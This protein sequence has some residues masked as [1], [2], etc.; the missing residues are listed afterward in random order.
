MCIAPY[1]QL[2]NMPGFLRSGH[3]LII[4]VLILVMFGWLNGSYYWGHPVWEDRLWVR[5][6]RG[7]GNP[8]R[9]V[10]ELHKREQQGINK[11]GPL[12]GAVNTCGPVKQQ[13]TYSNSRLSSYS[14]NISKLQQQQPATASSISISK[15]LCSKLHQAAAAAAS[16]ISKQLCRKLQQA[17]AL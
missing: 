5:E 8:D 12:V 4:T 17:P 6:Y 16:S 14:H 15:Q 3:I 9:L 11:T 7:T 1:A 13:A 2:D 10:W